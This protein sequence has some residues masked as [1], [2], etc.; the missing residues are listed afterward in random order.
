MGSGLDIQH[1]RFGP[2][3]S[4]SSRVLNPGTPHP[5]SSPTLAPAPA[6][7]RGTPGGRGGAPWGRP[8]TGSTGRVVSLDFGCFRRGK[9]VREAAFCRRS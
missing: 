6:L 3:H 7:A 5:S 8:G 4:P 1:L 9:T 2:T